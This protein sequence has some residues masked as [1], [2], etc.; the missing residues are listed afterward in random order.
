M[1]SVSHDSYGL[2]PVCGII[3]VEI[4]PVLGGVLGGYA[5]SLLHQ[6]I[7]SDCP[8]RLEIC[9][10]FRINCRGIFRIIGRRSLVEWPENPVAQERVQFIAEDLGQNSAE[11]YISARNIGRCSEA[12]TNPKGTRPC[13]NSIDSLEEVRVLYHLRLSLP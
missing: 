7:L 2:R 9:V 6:P 10:I 3:P 13:T 4:L 8:L 1:Q 12:T 5:Q 11:D